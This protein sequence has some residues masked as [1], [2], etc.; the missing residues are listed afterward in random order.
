MREIPNSWLIALGFVSL[1]TLRAMNYDSWITAMLSILV[2]YI[3]GKHIE[4]TKEL[5]N[6]VTSQK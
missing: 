4:Q 3:T 1:V 2:G 6:I 5:N